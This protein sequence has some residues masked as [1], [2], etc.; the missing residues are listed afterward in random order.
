MIGGRNNT[1]AGN[2]DSALCD[3]YDPM[4]DQWTTLAP[5]TCARNRVAV[6]VLDGQIY[7][8]GGGSGPD[9]Q[10]SVEHYDPSANKWT[11]GASMNSKRIGMLCTIH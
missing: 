10:S 2:A 1:P 6:G 4:I 9:L 5:L 11:R 8:V 7:A 3:G